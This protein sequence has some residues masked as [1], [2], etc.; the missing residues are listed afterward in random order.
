MEKIVRFFKTI[1]PIEEHDANNCTENS[2]I[3]NVGNKIRSF[4]VN[5]FIRTVRFYYAFCDTYLC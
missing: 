1:S 4:G 3:S 2:I 5:F